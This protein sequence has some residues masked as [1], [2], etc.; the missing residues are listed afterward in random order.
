MRIGELAERT[1]ASVRMLRYYDQH[2]LLTPQ[3]T[4]ARY[5]VY[6]E[7]DVARVRSVRCLIASGLNVRLVRLVLAHAFGEDVVLAADEMGCV[8][9]LE[10]LTEELASVNDRIAA[11]E[12]SREHL[13][14][15]VG[16]V[17]KLTEEH[18]ASPEGKAQCANGV[19]PATTA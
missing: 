17:R 13:T 3:R 11:L 6:E 14:K 1:G 10:I 19:R 15:L 18:W 12:T 8:P 4:E 16:D 5:R 2:G 9:L 7:S